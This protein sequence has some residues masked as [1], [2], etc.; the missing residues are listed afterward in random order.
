MGYIQLVK[1]EEYK[2]RALSQQ[3]TDITVEAERGTI[4][5]CNGEKLAQSVK[6]YDIYVYPAEIGKY[7]TKKE[8]KEL[9]D[10]TAKGLAETLGKDEDAVKKKID[11]KNGQIILAKGLTRED[12]DKVREL[13]LTGVMISPST[14]REYPN[15]TLA[16][17][18]MGMVNDENT[19]QSGLELEYNNYLS[20]IS[21]R[22]VNYTDTNGDELSYSPENERYYEAENGCDII[23]TIDLVIQSY[24]ESAIQKVQKKT[25][26]DRVFAVVM[27]S[28]LSLSISCFG[29]RQ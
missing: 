13:K 2:E 6:C 12:A 10:D 20:G 26:A 3:T 27:E 4:Y 14:K 15:G 8:R 22:I 11:Q 7:K 19:G 28:S 5:D 29:A 18:V 9:I 1:G 25:N 16:A 21:G 23:T 17:N 24:T